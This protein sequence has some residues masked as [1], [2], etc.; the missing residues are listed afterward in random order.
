MNC[1]FIYNPVSGKGRIRKKIK[2]VVDKL[3]EKYEIVDVYETRACGD[4]T[5]AAREAAKKYDAIVFSGGERLFQR[6]VAGGGVCGD[7][8]RTRLYSQRYGQRYRAFSAYPEK[9]PPGA[10]SHTRRGKRN[11]RLRESERALR[12]VRGGGGGFHECDVHHAAE[13]E[14][15]HR[16]NG[17]RVGRHQKNMRFDVFPVEVRN[18][19]ETVN[20]QSVF[21]LLMNGRYVAGMHINKKGQ[22]CRRKTGDRAR[23][24]DEKSHVF[25]ADT[26]IY[27]LGAP[28]FI[29]I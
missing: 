19:N 26:R 10:E 11:A 9:Y 28:V 25:K 8:A 27:S 4:M 3:R 6:S 22:F 5:A 16:Q 20:T 13:P 7:H 29:R 15:T 12:H 14:K 17:I 18:G 1:I 21:V 2:Y 24:A 23:Q